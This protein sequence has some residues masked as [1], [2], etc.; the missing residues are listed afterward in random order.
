MRE[1]TTKVFPRSDFVY[2]DNCFRELGVID[3]MPMMIINNDVK[4]NGEEINNLIIG[5]F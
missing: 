5:F 4:D 3:D 1:F 2:E